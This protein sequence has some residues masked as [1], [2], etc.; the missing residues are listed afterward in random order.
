M[1][2]VTQFATRKEIAVAFATIPASPFYRQLPDAL[3]WLWA[4]GCDDDSLYG[5]S[6]T[7]KKCFAD[8]GYR[9]P[10]CA[11]RSKKK[12]KFS[13]LPPWIDKSCALPPIPN[14]I[15]E[16]YL[17][18]TYKDFGYFV[19]KKCSRSI[20]RFVKTDS[21][22]QCDWETGVIKTV[23]L[24]IIHEASKHARPLHHR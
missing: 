19:C 17:V 21:P 16:S 22:D 11:A 6:H 20:K 3:R 14:W 2:K 10:I 18:L 7:M 24:T 9:C 12:R 5:K 23:A 13:Q 8:N 15:E 4:N 1:A